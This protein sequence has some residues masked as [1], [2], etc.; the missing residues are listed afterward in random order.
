[1][2][3]ANIAISAGSRKKGQRPQVLPSY[4]YFFNLFSLLTMIAV[5]M[6]ITVIP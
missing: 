1:L 2:A 3:T 6:T 4:R 5:Q